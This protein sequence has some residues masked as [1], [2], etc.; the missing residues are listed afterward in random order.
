MKNKNPRSKNCER[1]TWRV[2]KTAW[3]GASSI[4]M[5]KFP[6]KVDQH[7]YRT[8]KG[9][10]ETNSRFFFF[11]HPVVS[12]GQRRFGNDGAS[13]WNEIFRW[14][15]VLKENE[16]R[17][18]FHMSANAI[19]RQFGHKEEVVVD[20]LR[21]FKKKST[22]IPNDLPPR[23]VNFSVFFFTFLNRK[24]FTQLKN[25]ES[26]TYTDDAPFLHFL[27]VAVAPE[28]NSSIKRNK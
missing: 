26:Y 24:I 23:S 19:S 4:F 27:P 3:G 6:E 28:V 17:P 18:A 20:W 22:V 10:A 1:E 5:T 11:L 8:R 13:H 12:A 14:R 21:K 7:G 15:R 9:K 16:R 25:K 2:E